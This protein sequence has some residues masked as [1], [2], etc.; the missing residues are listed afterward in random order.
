MTTVRRF[1]C[2]GGGSSKFWEGWVVGSTFCARWGRLGSDGQRRA[3]ECASYSAAFT[4]MTKKIL[5]KQS[6]GYVEVRTSRYGEP[7]GSEDLARA[8]EISTKI[9]QREAARREN[10]R[11][12]REAERRQLLDEAVKKVNDQAL[13]P[14]GLLMPKAEKSKRKATKKP[15][16]DPAVFQFKRRRPKLG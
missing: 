16:P 10:V 13:K 12:S 4:R 3:W 5:E 15:A 8:N 6:K 7:L 11:L 1:E 14:F 9:S 2:T